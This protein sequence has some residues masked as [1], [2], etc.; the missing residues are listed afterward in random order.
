[1][2]DVTSNI[3]IGQYDQFQI[4]YRKNTADEKVINH[5]FSNDIFLKELD[6]Y[7]PSCGDTIV[8]I[9][10]HIGTFSVL[11]ADKIKPG[12]FFA[13][14][15]CKDTFNLLKIN[16][17]LNWLDNIK[18]FNCAISEESKKT[19]L[20]YDIG[21]WG[22]SIVCEMSNE[23]EEIDSITL[24]HLFDA[25]K[26]DK[27]NL[28]KM[29]CEGAEFPILF[30]TEKRIFDKIDNLLILYH[31]HLWKKQSPEEL[32]DFII[33]MGFKTYQRNFDGTNGWIIGHK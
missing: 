20:Y 21:N 17:C 19:R 2:R 4:A 11:A 30:A 24:N 5:S 32:N 26:I 16:S 31:R 14:E 3:F 33:R 28:L 7:K 29:N 23:Y 18:V 10:A 1:M 27:C 9:G 13:I 15:A 22:N 8:E 6:F 12:R 25:E